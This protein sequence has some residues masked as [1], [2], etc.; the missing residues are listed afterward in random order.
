MKESIVRFLSVNILLIDIENLCI[1]M[2][3]LK[4]SLSKNLFDLEFLKIQTGFLFY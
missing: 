1:L 2:D 3:N 4:L